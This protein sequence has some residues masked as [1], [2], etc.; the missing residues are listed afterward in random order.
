[1]FEVSGHRVILKDSPSGASESLIARFWDSWVSH[2]IE[3]LPL[4]LAGLATLR[5]GFRENDQ[6]I[7]LIISFDTEIG[8]FNAPEELDAKWDHFVDPTNVLVPL[9]I[10]EI[11]VFFEILHDF[12]IQKNEGVSIAKVFRLIVELRNAGIDC[13]LPDD[14]GMLTKLEPVAARTG[15]LVG[16]PYLY[17]ST[18]IDWL[19]DYFDNGLGA[20]LC[21]EMGLGKTFQAIGLISHAIESNQDEKILIVAPASLVANWTKEL[22]QFLPSAAFDVH[23][24]PLR[25]AKAS[26]FGS[27]IIL[28]TYETLIR[29]RFLVSEL[30][31]MLVVA[32]EAQALKNFRSQR[33]VAV[34]NLE[35][36]SKVLVT[37]TP[38][39]NKLADLS[40]LVNIVHPGLLGQPEDFVEMIED[41]P[42]EARELGRLASPM[43]LRR[44][45]AEVA[46]DLPE[47]VMV[48]TP[49]S[50]SHDFTSVYES[51]RLGCLGKPAG[52]FLGL[53]TKL[54][55]ACC[56]PQ[57]IEPGFR[58]PFDTKIARLMEVLS[59]IHE[60]GKDK[61]LVFT[62][63]KDS[64]DMLVG[65]LSR[66]FGNDS[67]AFIDGRVTP[68]DRQQ[69]V[70]SF[71]STKGF[72]A[73]IINPKAGGTGLNITGA[74]HV[75][76]FN[77]QWNPAV[78]AQANA[79]SYRR[80]QEKTVFVHRFYYL[81]TV[82]EI[83]HE[84]LRS[85]LDLADAA[86]EFSEQTFDLET[87]TKYLTI[88]PL[89]ER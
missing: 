7:S 8:T 34:K 78:E 89:A 17:Q 25:A 53:I 81:G 69:I 43:I 38:V 61:I 70:D 60:I 46:K 29:D 9:R 85:K 20:L 21:D 24:G 3:S 79:R 64:I 58:D 57:L 1:V 2:G 16:T 84:R 86:L 63:F 22:K 47:L 26:D 18:G 28:T 37:G 54:S 14:F 41:T 59:E 66:A 44:R 50:P 65:H 11:Q 10:N 4:E 49:L 48:D 80:K 27:R 30:K 74:N 36:I 35:C 51:L 42:A 87:Q 13:D 83:M 33:H 56:S 55:Q 6:E 88:S 19:T 32:D 15:A 71:N 23:V 82:E 12:G 45:V 52:A 62:T 39:E 31:L 73:L 5:V 40:A 72:K 75:I 68:S 67:V 76:H 77:R